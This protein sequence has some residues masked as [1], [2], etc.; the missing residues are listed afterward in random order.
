MDLKQ[1][2]TKHIP[3]VQEET[4]SVLQDL[5]DKTDTILLAFIGSYVP[6]RYGPEW[7]VE[8][9]MA[10]EEEFSIEGAL[11][12][13]KER[14]GSKKRKLHLLVNSR[15]GLTTSSFKIAMAIRKFFDDITV[16]VPHIAASGGT[17]LALT[18]NKIRMGMMSQ[19]SPVDV[20][21]LYKGQFISANSLLAAKE[22]I[23]DR[24][25]LKS[26][27]ELSYLDKHLAESFDPATLIEMDNVVEMS[28]LYLDRI[29][30]VVGYSE[31]KRKKITQKLI[32]DLPTH[33][34]VIQADLAEEMGI[35]VES[36]S[37]D[38]EEWKLM[39]KWLL[40]YIDKA[41]DRHFVRYIIPNK[42]EK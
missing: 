12:S 22:D 38:S 2:D 7:F 30:T 9:R 17:I 25:A 29:L 16:F 14:H 5:A 24:L 41:A 40:K 8:S 20:Q 26:A 32:F 19:L 18:G 4:D 34:F 11:T 28:E 6:R 15:G 35:E 36:D 39:R 1:E 21:I 27:G 33:G 13:I 23:A 42:K 37:V 31:A 10:V 3:N